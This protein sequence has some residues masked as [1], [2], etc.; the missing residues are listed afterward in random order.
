MS[1]KLTKIAYQVS[2]MF[3]LTSLYLFFIFHKIIFQIK[4]RLLIARRRDFPFFLLI[5]IW[6]ISISLI[7]KRKSD[8]SF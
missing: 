6:K 2:R 7:C 3:D 5:Q 1:A 4:I 8:H